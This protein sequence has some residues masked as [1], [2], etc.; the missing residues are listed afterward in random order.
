MTEMYTDP[1]YGVKMTHIFPVAQRS[2]PASGEAV[3]TAGG[4]TRTDMTQIFRM[5]FKAKICKYGVIVRSA[6]AVKCSSDTCFNLRLLSHAAHATEV[7]SFG[8]AGATSVS[9]A[10]QYATGRAPETATNVKKGRL[11]VPAISQEAKVGAQGTIMHFMEYQRVYDGG[12]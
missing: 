10:T 8:P 9:L 5:P 2:G 3:A 12:N 7:A 4:S 6:S 1:C 11:L